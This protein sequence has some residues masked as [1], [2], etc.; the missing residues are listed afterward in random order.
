MESGLHELQLGV[1]VWLLISRMSSA[2]QSSG[3]II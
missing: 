3:Q 1:A 2:C